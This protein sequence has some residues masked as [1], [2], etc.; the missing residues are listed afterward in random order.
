MKND[1]ETKT[2]L[3]ELKQV[4]DVNTNLAVIKKS[5]QLARYIADNAD[6]NNTIV[7]ETKD[8]EKIKLRL[9]Q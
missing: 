2:L 5:L 1:K 8:N 7:I 6:K 4:F 9:S 3:N